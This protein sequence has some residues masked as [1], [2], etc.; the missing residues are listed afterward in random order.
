[1]SINP[2]NEADL[3]LLPLATAGDWMRNPR[4]Y[5]ERASWLREAR[6]TERISD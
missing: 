5:R 1:M 4:R 2:M 6:P 3:N